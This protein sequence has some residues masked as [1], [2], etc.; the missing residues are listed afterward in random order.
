[1]M[2]KALRWRRLRPSKKDFKDKAGAT[3][4]AAKEVGKLIAERG[5]KAQVNRSGLRSRWLISITAA[6]RRWQKAHAKAAWHSNF[7]SHPREF[8][9]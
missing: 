4:D 1:M 2:Q 8:K 6:S 5:K 9:D 3:T 7:Q